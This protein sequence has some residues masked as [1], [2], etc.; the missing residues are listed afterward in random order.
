MKPDAQIEM[1]QMI[2]PTASISR[3]RTGSSSVISFTQDSGNTVTR[4]NSAKLASGAKAP[5]T[6]VRHSLNRVS[7]GGDGCRSRDFEQ[8][9]EFR[10]RDQPQPREQ[11][12]DVDRQR[13]E[14]G[15]APAPAEEVLRRTG[16][17]RK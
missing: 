12:H 4:W 5:S 2:A 15:I 10:R 16:A 7:N 8:A 13:D 11:R 9:L 14:E 3:K 17:P 1:T 6:I